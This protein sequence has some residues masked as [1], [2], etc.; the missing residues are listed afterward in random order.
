MRGRSADVALLGLRAALGIGCVLHGYPQ[1]MHPAT[2]LVA[3]EAFVELAGGIAVLAGVATSTFAF[4]IGCD[5]A[6]AIF[7]GRI[8]PGGASSSAGRPESLELRLAYL[9]IAL[10]LILLGPG[11]FALGTPRGSPRQPARRRH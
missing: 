11:A 5:M 6:G 8:L 2:W 3:L 10:A 4:L 7:F 1:A 9:A